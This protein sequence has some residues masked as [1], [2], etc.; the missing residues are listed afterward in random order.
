MDERGAVWKPLF[1][2]AASTLLVSLGGVFDWTLLAGLS[3]W[4]YREIITERIVQLVTPVLWF[5]PA[6]LLGVL[7]LLLVFV[8]RSLFDHSVTAEFEIGKP[9]LFPCKTTHRRMFPKKHAFAYS[10]LV[11]GI[12]VGWKGSAGGLLS[13]EVPKT[14]G[15]F[16][17]LVKR[18]WTWFEVRSED[19]LRRGSHERGLRGKLDEFLEQEVRS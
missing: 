10:Y 8:I 16:R 4:H 13:A 17:R 9:A 3:V 5:G 12:P 2:L 15:I 1:A 14:N 18:S 6:L 7:G 11:A 19:H